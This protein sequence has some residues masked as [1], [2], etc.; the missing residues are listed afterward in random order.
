MSNGISWLDLVVF[1]TGCGALVIAGLV[2]WSKSSQPALDWLEAFFLSGVGTVVALGWMGVVLAT[3]GHFSVMVLGVIGYV[4]AT[5]VVLLNRPIRLPRFRRLTRYE[6]ALL[7]LLAGCAIVFFRPHEYVLGG[8][9]AGTYMNIS[10]TVAR[11]GRFV[12]DDSWTRFLAEFAP[13]TLRQQPAPAQTQYL[14]FVGYY[15]D[16][17]D[18][19]RVIPQF[20]PFHPILIAIGTALG[21]LSLGLLVTPLWGV[22]GIAA[23]Y[24]AARKWFGAQVALLA[25]TLLALTPTTIYFARY[26]T[27]EPLTLLL[28]FSGLLAFQTLYDDA[29]ASVWWGVWGGA[30]FGAAFLTRIDL[31]IL[32][33]VLIFALVWLR[34]QG[35]WSRGWTFFTLVLG[36]LVAHT[37]FNM[38]LINWPYVWNTY[39]AA[40]RLV[41]RLW[42]LAILIALSLVAIV[43]FG[44]RRRRQ[45][46]KLT[47]ISARLARLFRLLLIV[48]LVGLSVY[49]YAVR[50]IVEPVQVFTA[51]PGNVEVPVLNG[52]N[53]VRLGWY[54][55]PLGL[56]LATVG[57]AWI[58][59]RESLERLMLFLLAGVL[60]TV[61]YVYNIMN[62]PYLI[63]AMR[64]YVP[65]VIP[66]LLIYAAYALVHMYQARSRRVMRFS[67]GVLTIAL[68]IGLGYQSRLVVLPRDFFGA[69]TQLAELNGRLRPDAIVLMAEPSESVLSDNFGVP[70]RFIFGHDIATLHADNASAAPFLDRLLTRAAELNRPVQVLAL[71]PI[72]SAINSLFELQPAG[73]ISLHWPVLETSFY[74]NPSTVLPAVYNFDIYDVVGK[75]SQA[76]ISVDAI[77]VGSADLRY[78]R[79]GF[80]AKEF[81]P[82]GTTARWTTDQATIE[83]PLANTDPVAIEVKAMTF[84]PGEIPPAEVVVEL[85]GAQ[86]G[87]FVP[88]PAWQTY[89]F[90]A[91]P[92]PVNGLSTLQLKTRTFNPA[93]LQL[94]ADNRDLGFLLDGIKVNP[95]Q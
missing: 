31:P 46:S 95:A 6:W 33:V 18:P 60:T 91:R 49:A 43:V 5:V 7:I 29:Q 14:Q 11:T 88:T 2:L 44:I 3:L 23:V 90:T 89:S 55:T 79:T 9:D 32:L 74:K 50:P 63:Y 4:L 58:I 73:E 87:R 92:R 48:V 1:S 67:A 21:G 47:L 57:V 84:R 53:W 59:W 66:M 42:P 86:I 61:Q 8:S 26:P 93:E 64:R 25:A 24:L 56:A 15:L 51:W 85:D 77:D 65:I 16:N 62:M 19:G 54:L 37:V 36:A 17:A 70:L 69:V 45:H 71:N 72:P 75:R 94:S 34:V 20:F 82:D 28:I 10:A 40:F 13:V 80:Y 22:L 41:G 30:A 27:T 76:P 12:L 39:Y 52:Q 68:L 38:V 35:R 83:L 81:L 78:I